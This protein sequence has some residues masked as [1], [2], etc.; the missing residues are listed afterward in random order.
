[1]LDRL[2]AAGVPA[3]PCLGFAEIFS[4]PFLR[5]SGCIAEQKHP[6]LGRVL[7][8]GPMIRFGATPIVYR[9]PASLLGADGAEVLREV[10]YTTARIA[11]LMDAGVVGRPAA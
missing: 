3:A 8:G 10:G 4:E 7:M 1:V 2:A 5:A 9:R 11:A 6:T